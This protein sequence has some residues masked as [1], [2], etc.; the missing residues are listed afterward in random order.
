MSASVKCAT[1]SSHRQDDACTHTFTISYRF[2][3]E[4][5]DVDTLEKRL[6]HLIYGQF[7]MVL[8][9]MGATPSI[10]EEAHV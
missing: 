4:G 9:E 2:D 3:S 7:S 6:K 10:E 1:F 8:R 5:V